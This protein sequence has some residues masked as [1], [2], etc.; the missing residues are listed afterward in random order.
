MSER[1]S[2]SG[3]FI[4][5]GASGAS[6]EGLEGGTGIRSGEAKME[7]RRSGLRAERENATPPA[8][9]TSAHKNRRLNVRYGAFARVK[10]GTN[11]GWRGKLPL[12]ANR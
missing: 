5:S 2:S 4:R 8:T 10:N 1:P 3:E 9:G 12:D 11:D 7:E 6:S